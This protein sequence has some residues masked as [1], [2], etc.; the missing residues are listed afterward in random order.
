MIKIN[1][2]YKT[3]NRGDVNEVR[4]LRGLNLNIGEGEFVTVIGSN[5]AGKST[6]LNLLAGVFPPDEGEIWI[7]DRNVTR[8]PEHQ[9]AKLISRVFQ[10]PLKGTA[11][12][13][14]IEE[15]MAM[16]RLRGQRRGFGWGVTQG[17]R[18]QFRQE[19]AQLGLGL[20][21]RLTGKVNLLSGGQRQA[22]TLIM[23]TLVKPRILLLDEHTAALDPGMAAQISSLTAHLVHD[24]KLTAL[25][26]THNMPQA[27][28]MG[29]RTRMMHKGEIILDLQGEERAR[30]TVNDLVQK[31]ASIRKDA[32]DDELLLS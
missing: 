17:G 4:A 2:V 5:G 9:R 3:F 31:F 16:A 28:S 26:V 21:D 20:E 7:A 11:G 6:M 10:D 18:N 8:W 30:L 19:L 32:L 22:L 27:L 24:H 29:S 25:M 23:A 1:Q 12:S 14:T 15:N 13:M